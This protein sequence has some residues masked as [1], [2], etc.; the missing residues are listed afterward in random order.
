MKQLVRGT[1][2]PRGVT[3]TMKFV[4]VGIALLAMIV[5][6]SA[7]GTRPLSNVGRFHGYVSWPL[8]CGI[9]RCN[10]ARLRAMGVSTSAPSKTS[11]YCGA[12]CQRKA[13]GGGGH[14]GANCQRKAAATFGGRQ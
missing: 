2:K 14:C 10:D 1:L 3:V 8:Y 7:Q 4:F 11:N 9:A 5:S 12:N 13:F 6:A